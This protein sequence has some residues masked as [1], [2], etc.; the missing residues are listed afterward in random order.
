MQCNKSHSSLSNEFNWQRLEVVGNISPQFVYPSQLFCD[1]SDVSWVVLG[2]C[3]FLCLP[4]MCPCVLATT[5]QP[6]GTRSGGGRRYQFAVE[7]RSNQRPFQLLSWF[8]EK[9][10]LQLWVSLGREGRVA[11]LTGNLWIGGWSERYQNIH[12]KNTFRIL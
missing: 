10:L 12:G 6:T 7:H 3:A 11:P 1:A 9:R 8:S 4:Q 5:N 2:Q